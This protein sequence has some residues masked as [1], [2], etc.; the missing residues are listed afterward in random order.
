M[1]KIGV[2]AGACAIVP[3][4]HPI[5]ILAGN[6]LKITVDNNK[7]DIQYLVHQFQ[8]YKERGVFESLFS[9]T[10]QPALSLKTLKK[11]QI[12]YPPLS[13]QTQIAS[14]LSEVDTKIE[15]EEA[16]KAELEQLKKGLMQVLL[17]G[18]VRVK[19]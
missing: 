7:C 3:K 8:R 9:T 15:K 13:E 11:I 18:K 4:D 19:A 5:S 6:S 10:A 14:I 1:A 12:K 16:T 17:T 2:N